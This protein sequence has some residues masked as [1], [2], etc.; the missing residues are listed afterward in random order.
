MCGATGVWPW[1]RWVLVRLNLLKILRRYTYSYILEIQRVSCCSVLVSVK[2][3]FY[4]FMYFIYLPT[5]C[6]H[7]NISFLICFMIVCVCVCVCVWGGLGCECETKKRILFKSLRDTSTNTCRGLMQNI[8]S[9]K[10]LKAPLLNR[11][12]FRASLSL[13]KN[14]V[15]NHIDSIFTKLN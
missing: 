12:F 13:R 6:L 10:N 7:Q 4:L 14:G 5:I 2:S 9:K 1:S 8:F 3:C 11:N 15:K